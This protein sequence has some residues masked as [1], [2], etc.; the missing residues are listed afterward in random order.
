MDLRLKP[1]TVRLLQPSCRS[2][3][4]TVLALAADVAPHHRFVPD[5]CLFSCQGAWFAFSCNNSVVTSHILEEKKMFAV[6]PAGLFGRPRGPTFTDFE[7][8]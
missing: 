1:E 4:T 7:Q 2:G 3:L 5:E 8:F 6:G